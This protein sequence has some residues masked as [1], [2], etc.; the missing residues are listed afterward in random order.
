VRLDSDD[1]VLAADTCYFCRTLRERRL[2]RYVH[3]RAAMLASLDRWR[4]S[5]RSVRASSSAMTILDLFG[6]GGFARDRVVGHV[7]QHLGRTPQLP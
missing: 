2:P 3:D 5:K 4:R 6:H 7:I 1:V